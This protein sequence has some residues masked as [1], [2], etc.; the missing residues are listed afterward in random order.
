MSFPWHGGSP[1]GSC[2]AACVG[3][4]CS[5]PAWRWAWRRSPPPARP[6]RRSARAGRPGPGDSRRRRRVS[7][8]QRRFTPAERATWRG[9]G[10]VDYAVAS[11]AMAQAPSGERRLV[12]LRGVSEDYPLAG[13]V[14]L[15]GGLT[16]AQAF[17]PDGD[18]Q[19]AAVEKP[20][21]DRLGTEA[22]RPFPGR[23]RADRGAGGA[24][25]RA[26]PAV[27][28]FRARSKGADPDQV[29]EEAGGFLAP[30]LP[31]GETARIALPQAARPARSR[32]A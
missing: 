15:A 18:A 9:S 16:L 7:I 10:A 31:F 27:A 1:R 11:Q 6:A 32:R 12:E 24:G 23:Q 19:G 4:G 5:S 21:L 8:G 29:L 25:R 22:R 2:G 30:G 20:L 14:D 13:K 17:T 28:G 26:G 3:F